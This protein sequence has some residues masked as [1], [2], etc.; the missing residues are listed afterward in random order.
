MST[1]EVDRKMRIC[2]IFYGI[3]ASIVVLIFSMPFDA[4]AQ[5]N[6]VRIEVSETTTAED[7]DAVRLAAEAASE[8][9]ARR[10]INKLLWFGAGAG[11]CCI[12]GA[13]GGLTGAF[14]G[15]LIAP[16][17]D[18]G[19]GSLAPL[20]DFGDGAA[21]G[22]IV[23]SVAGVSIPFNWIYNYQTDPL[24]ERLL[25]K[26]PQYVEFYTDTYRSKT[27]SL[28]G[29]WVAAGVGGVVGGLLL[30]WMLLVQQ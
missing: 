26:S 21:V 1:K 15:N 11:V 27:R 25:G 8:Q 22:C 14:V 24:P 3:G 13:I 5:Q 16:P 4:F 23:G 18:T 19:L 7:A 9:D 20:L 2:S 6:P 10:D 30:S 29:R 12:G 28:R 17:A